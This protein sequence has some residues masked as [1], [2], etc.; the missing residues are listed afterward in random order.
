MFLVH[1]EK[2][3]ARKLRTKLMDDFGTPVTLSD[4][5]MV[6]DLASMELIDP[7]VPLAKDH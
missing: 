3:S 5:G 2:K 4:P 1:G 7:G 6:L